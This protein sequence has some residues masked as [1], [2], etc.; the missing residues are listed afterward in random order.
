MA[1]PI[2][3]NEEEI[4]KLNV[5]LAE[6]KFLV[7][8]CNHKYIDITKICSMALSCSDKISKVV[9]I[10]VKCSDI[11]IFTLKLTNNSNSHIS[12]DNEFFIGFKFNHKPG[13]LQKYCYV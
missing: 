11:D 5:A 8:E 6:I 3:F 4:S 9:P 12:W 10:F 1:Y 2:I 7:R 13:F